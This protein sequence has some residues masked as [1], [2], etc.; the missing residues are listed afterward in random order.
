MDGT[1]ED[2]E[3]EY[4]LLARRLIPI[5]SPRSETSIVVP[6]SPPVLNPT[7]GRLVAKSSIA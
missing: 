6:K 4:L 5:S 7:S 2:E 1:E 3:E